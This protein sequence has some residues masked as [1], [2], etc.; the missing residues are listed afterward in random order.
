MKIITNL[1]KYIQTINKKDLEKYLAIFIGIVILFC[2]ISLYKI[3]EKSSVL[4]Q[5]IKTTQRLAKKAENM[6][7]KNA[8]LNLKEKLLHEKLKENKEFNIQTF[9]EQFWTQNQIKPETGWG[10]TKILPIPGNDNFDEIELTAVFK[11]QTTEKLTE[12]INELNKK[13]MIYIKQV[14][15]KREPNNK[16]TFDLTLATMKYKKSL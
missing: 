11:N 8:V 10:E 15:I 3:Y 4:I 5:K 12:L 6:I 9:L 14:T 1:A 13:D 2:T 16:I 7:K